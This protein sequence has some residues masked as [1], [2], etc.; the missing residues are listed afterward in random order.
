MPKDDDYQGMLAR[1]VTLSQIGLVKTAMQQME[2]LQN[3][4]GAEVTIYDPD[5]A[6]NIA[7]IWW[8]SEFDCWVADFTPK[9]DT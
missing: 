2:Q 9:E 1:S 7:T 3:V 6:I 5:T 4:Y 8:C